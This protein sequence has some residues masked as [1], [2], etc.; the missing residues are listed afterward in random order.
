[1]GAEKAENRGDF[2][3]KLVM[4]GRLKNYDFL[5]IDM[6]AFK[7][8]LESPQSEFWGKSYDCFTRTAQVQLKLTRLCSSP[9][10]GTLL[11]ESCFICK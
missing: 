2:E 4:I 6:L 3:I 9:I 7:M 8:S 5:W 10:L 1:M 11:W